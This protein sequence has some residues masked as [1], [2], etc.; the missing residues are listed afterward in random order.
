MGK[1]I[2]EEIKQLRCKAY[3]LAETVDDIEDDQE[4]DET[5]AEIQ[6]LHHR[7]DCLEENED[8]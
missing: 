4:H 1:R 2:Q 7:A 5:I 6:K 3:Q 8:Y